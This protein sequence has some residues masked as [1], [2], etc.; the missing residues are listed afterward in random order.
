MTIPADTPV[1]AGRALKALVDIVMLVD[2]DGAPTPA[3]VLLPAGSIIRAWEPPEE[4]RGEKVPITL[5]E[6]QMEP[7]RGT[8][9]GSGHFIGW[10]EFFTRCTPADGPGSGRSLVEPEN[11]RS[12]GRPADFRPAAL[13]PTLPFAAIA[14]LRQ[15][16]RARVRQQ[17]ASD[18]M[19]DD[20]LA[21]AEALERACDTAAEMQLGAEGFDNMETA[22]Y[23]S[24]VRAHLASAAE[25]L[26]AACRALLK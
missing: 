22:R 8:V 12:D 6:L 10:D 20:L 15:P 18:L 24:G 9:S 23:F 3:L 1:P 14:T 4:W 17:M 2:D 7:G 19:A 25:E 21:I 13:D 11:V 16:L 5:G 26:L